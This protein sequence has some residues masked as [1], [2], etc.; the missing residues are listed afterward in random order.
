VDESPT[1]G[2]NATSGT[3]PPVHFF[4]NLC[5]AARETGLRV[6]HHDHETIVHMQLLAMEECRSGI[7]RHKINFRAAETRDGDHILHHS[8]RALSRDIDQFKAMPVQ[9]KRMFVTAVVAKREAVSPAFVYPQ[10]LYI[11]K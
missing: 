6:I 3:N 10:G 11:G 1:L 5:L 2:L 8:S 9:M 7:V 4:L